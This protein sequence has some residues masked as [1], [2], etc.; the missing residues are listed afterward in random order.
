VGPIC[1]RPFFS[2]AAPSLSLSRGPGSPVAESLHRAPLSSLSVPWA[3]PVSSAPST[4]AVDR[5]VRTRA[6]HLISRPRRPPTSPASFLEPRGAPRT[7]LASLRSAFTLSRALPSS[8]DATRDPRLRCRPSSSLETAPSLT[9]L[10]PEVRHPSPCPISL[11]APC[12]RPISHSPVLG[13]GGPPC[14]CG[15]QLI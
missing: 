4:L 8:P 10:H 14:S 7:P 3:C 13:R 6:R 5:C 2:P 12:V 1:R 9:E 11:I 15:G